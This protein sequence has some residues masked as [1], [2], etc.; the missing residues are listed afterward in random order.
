M[1]HNGTIVDI[2]QKALES[3]IKFWNSHC[4]GRKNYHGVTLSS[5]HCKNK[6][7]TKS[8]DGRPICAECAKD[9]EEERKHIK[10]LKKW[11]LF[12]TWEKQYGSY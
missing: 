4:W 11:G 6:P 8:P 12:E 7:T 3:E 5:G 1:I 9:E 10:D 2:N